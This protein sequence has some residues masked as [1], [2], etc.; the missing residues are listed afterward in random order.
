MPELGRHYKAD[1]MILGGDIT[2]KAL[3][4]VIHDGGESRH[5]TLQEF[6]TERV[7]QVSSCRQV[8]A[9]RFPRDSCSRVGAHV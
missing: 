3:V 6:S 5:G 1:V 2:G 7:R 9:S 4:P 8:S